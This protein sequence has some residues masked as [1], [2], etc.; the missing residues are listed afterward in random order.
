M[1]TTRRT[2]ML[3][4]AASGTL[5]RFAIAQGAEPVRIGWLAALTGASSAPAIGFNRGVL[6]AADQINAGRAARSRSSPAT[7]RATPPR[8]STPPRS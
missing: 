5:A 7:P 6:F 3:G 1:H 4:A 2:L 8:P